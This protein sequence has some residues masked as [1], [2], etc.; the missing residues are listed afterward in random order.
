MSKVKVVY[1]RWVAYELRK[2]GLKIL[3]TEPNPKH[4]ELDCWIFK[5]TTKFQEALEKLS[6]KGRN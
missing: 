3:R 6:Q 1:T 4:P 5:D 2:Q